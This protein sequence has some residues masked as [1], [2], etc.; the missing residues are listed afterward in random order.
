MDVR[1][2]VQSSGLDRRFKSSSLSLKIY[3]IKSGD[4]DN[5]D[6]VNK[7]GEMVVVLNDV[8]NDN[9]GDDS[10]EKWK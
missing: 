5:G 6:M 9:I 8:D 1:K 3:K 10:I 4:S 2:Q 7:R